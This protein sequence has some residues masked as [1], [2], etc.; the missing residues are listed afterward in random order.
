MFIHPLSGSQL[1][2]SGSRE[3]F[4]V[5]DIGKLESRSPTHVDMVMKRLGFTKMFTR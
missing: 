1:A 3:N 4:I 2:S 5:P